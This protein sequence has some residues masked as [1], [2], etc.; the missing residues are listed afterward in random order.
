MNSRS[1]RAVLAAIA[2]VCLA[3]TVR[4]GAQATAYDTSRT[5]TLKGRVATVI[6]QYTDRT[7]L[8]LDVEGEAGR[9]RWA[10][11][12]DGSSDLGWAPQS[13][14]LKLGETVS[15]D[16]FRARPGANLANLVPED[17]PGLQEIAKAGRIARG[18]ELTVAGGRK[19]AFGSR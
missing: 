9:E 15:I 2:F 17:H 6:L 3:M 10:I 11:E 14:P 16:V 19:L 12:G 13:L 8:V 5:V 18:L 7:F 4:M 1:T